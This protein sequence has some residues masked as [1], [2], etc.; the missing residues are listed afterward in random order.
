[1]KRVFFKGYIPLKKHS[2]FELE[3]FY[4]TSQLITL[5]A[6]DYLRFIKRE[7]YPRRH[8][9]I[10]AKWKAKIKDKAKSIKHVR[11]FTEHLFSEIDSNHIRAYIKEEF[12]P[13]S[14]KV[15]QKYPQPKSEEE[16]KMAVAQYLLDEQKED[17]Q[18]HE[19]EENAAELNSLGIFRTVPSYDYT[20]YTLIFFGHSFIKYLNDN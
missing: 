4:Q 7:I 13:E 8:A 15:K 1:V 19:L 2:E 9:S 18:I 10:D 17:E 11:D 16:I 3:R 20:G 14:P 12:S 5:K 6:V